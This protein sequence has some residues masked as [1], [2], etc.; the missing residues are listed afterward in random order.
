[1]MKSLLTGL[2]GAVSLMAALTASAAQAGPDKARAEAY[3]NA[4]S[5]GNAETIA[6]FYADNAEFYWVGGP[7]AGSYKG[8]AKIKGVWE[9]FS[10]AAGPLD[11]KVLELSESPGGKRSTVTARVNFIGPKEVPVKFILVYQEG[12]I[13]SEVW[14]VDKPVSYA[15][16]DAPASVSAPVKAEPAQRQAA[17]T[18]VPPAGE[19][20][21]EER[22][23]TPPEGAAGNAGPAPEAPADAAAAVVSAVEP[24]ADA[25]PAPDEA[26][27]PPAPEAVPPAP[28]GK[29]YIAPE[30]KKAY[31]GKKKPVQKY[32]KHYEE[33]YDDYPEPYYGHYGYSRGYH[34]YGGHRSH[35]GHGGYGGY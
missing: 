14:Q 28:K 35:R 2:A 3:F 34:G 32:S 19:G 22:D 30:P 18:P 9:K 26:K 4:I 24:P 7:L 21:P 27:A 17:A 29:A 15:G 20:E 10:K 25:P 13:V 1:M 12:K 31:G 11:Y 23:G 8:K 16:T 6:S 33:D 5:G